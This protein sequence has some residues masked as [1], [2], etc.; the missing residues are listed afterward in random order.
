MDDGRAGFEIIRAEEFLDR[1]AAE[2]VEQIR[3]RLGSAPVY[4]SV[5]IDV[6]DPAFAPA[7]G[8]PEVAGISTSQL[9]AVLRGLRGLDIVGC[10]VVEVAPAYDHAGITGL[11]AA[12]TAWELV[13]L[14]GLADPDR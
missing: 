3:A 8:T 6:L 14:I 11:A 12:H 13:T 9:F 2:L 1:S 10:D 5:D 7:T 4:V